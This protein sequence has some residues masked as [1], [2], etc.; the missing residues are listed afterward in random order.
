MWFIQNGVLV[1]HVNVRDATYLYGAVN[2]QDDDNNRNDNDGD[3]D[4]NGGNDGCSGD[5]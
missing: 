2:E 5:K 3:D 1:N 4:S